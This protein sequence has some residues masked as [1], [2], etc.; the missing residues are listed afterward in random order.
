VLNRLDELRELQL[1]DPCGHSSMPLYLTRI[2]DLPWTKHKP[3][4]EV[5]IKL[6]L[7]IPYWYFFFRVIRHWELRNRLLLH[8][9]GLPLFTILFQSIYYYTSELFGYFH[10]QGSGKVWDIYIPGLFYILQFGIFHAYEYYQDAQRNIEIRSALR[11]AA[12]KSELS[13]LKAQLNPHFLYNVFNTIS[14]S[15]PPEQEKT[16]E[17]IAKLSDLFRYQLK[18]TNLDSVA[19]EDELEFVKTYLDLEQER[20]QDRLTYDIHIDKAAMGR[21]IPPML[22]QPIV[23]NAVKHGISPRIEGGKVMV[24]VNAERDFTH[25]EIQ[26]D[27]VGM[28]SEIKGEGI[29][30][31]NTRLRLKKMFNEELHILSSANSGVNIQFR[32][33]N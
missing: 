8:L 19:V 17:M 23:E 6:L 15:V 11:E 32:I 29:G 26:D 27:G 21:D 18:A 2:I 25:F 9:L 14:A 5:F 1:V 20:F 4:H 13:A 3:G 7:T 30:L 10:L 33:P 28:Q 22:I 31:S 16:R 12:L 24:K